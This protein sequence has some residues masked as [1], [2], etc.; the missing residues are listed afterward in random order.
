LIADVPVAIAL[1]GGLDSSI[2]AAAA[3]H[4]HP[5]L[6]AFTFTLSPATDPEVEH[7]ALV[8]QHLGLD[9][10]VARM[11]PCK[12]EGWLRRVAWHLE[13]P[14]ANVNALLSFGLAGVVRAH[15]FKVVLV[16]EGADE[17]FGGYP[18][19]RY[20]LD[21]RL[22]ST[23]GAVFDAYR[24]RRAQSGSSRY[25]RAQA[26]ALASPRLHAQRLAFD[27]ALGESPLKGFLS[28]DQ[29]TQLQHSQLLRVDRMFMAHG[30]EA[31]V[32]FLYR[33]V[34]QA[35]AA[36]PDARLLPPL[37]NPGRTE[38]L[39]LAEAFADT[40]PES[41]TARP[42]FG[43]QGSVNI[44]DSWVASGLTDEFDRCLHGSE[45]RGAR[46]LLEQFIDWE[47]IGD[48][49]VPPKEKFALSLLLECVD[50]LMLSRE[51]PGAAM[52]VPWE[53]VQ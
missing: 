51:H 49:P 26:H 21:P 33:S 10:R 16:G 32:P 25:V 29:Q 18:W 27:H 23:P 34:L 13:E 37:G 11:V 42:K 41:I 24:R 5:G 7:A 52:P 4:Q 1:S 31:R 9:H 36:I 53:I 48:A 39:A 3:A 50:G 8:C 30:V 19:Y 14:V 45:L 46:Q 28:F 43:E 2:V 35:S 38:K 12:M 15:G 20:A 40:L 6:Q 44:W 22:A 17:L 47:S